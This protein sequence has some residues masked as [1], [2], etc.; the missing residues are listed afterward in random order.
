VFN[1][2][3]V[4]PCSQ[5]PRFGYHKFLTEKQMKDVVAYIFSPDSPVNK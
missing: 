3:A 5:M 2:Q 4:M 1:A